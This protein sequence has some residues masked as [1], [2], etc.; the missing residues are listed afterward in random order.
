MI[1][2]RTKKSRCFDVDSRAKEYLKWSNDVAKS[3]GAIAYREV[4]GDQA[5]LDAMYIGG[6]NAYYRAYED[7]RGDI[8]SMIMEGRTVNDIAKY[9]NLNIHEL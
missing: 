4:E 6:K 9:L 7:I 1:M 2:S 8:A 3:C 5:Y